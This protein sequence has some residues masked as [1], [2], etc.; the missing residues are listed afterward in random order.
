MKRILFF[1]LVA[2]MLSFST[3][4][5][6]NDSQDKRYMVLGVAF[7]NLENLFDTINNNGKYDLEFSP[8]GAKKWDSEKYHAKLNNMA[9]AIASLA[10][11]VTPLGPA[12]IGVA[13]IE[14]RS[15]LDDLVKNEQ[16]KEWQ[17]QVIHHDSP[18]RRGIDV[19]LLYNPYYFKPLHVTNHTLVIDGDS[20]FRT[21]DQMCVT[22]LLSGEKV[23]VIV[24]HWPSRLGGEQRSSHLREAA[25]ALSKHIADSV[26]NVD[27]N[28][29]VIIMGDLNDDP[30]NK[31]CSK[32][33]GAKKERKKVDEHGFFNPF[34]KT[35]DKGIGSLAYRG[36]WN[37][38]DQI[39]IS[40]NTLGGKQTGLNYLSH[41]VHNKD[42]LTQQDGKYSGYPLRT[43]SGVKFLNGYSDHYPTIVYFLK[44]ITE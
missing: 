7:Y 8:E 30:F 28:Q 42:F 31:S 27:P 12:I 18:D 43:F 21:R 16:I 37:L 15:V 39:I 25:A 36:V 4:A 40:G 5:Q 11:E 44:E 26:W 14:N 41:R 17:L 6:S 24:N 23:S 1:S 35:L 29:A 2:I 22:G 10:T 19:G 32:I 13:E 33:L 34:W 3:W 38:F 9:Q 20:T